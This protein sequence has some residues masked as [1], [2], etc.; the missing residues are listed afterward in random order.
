MEINVD[1]IRSDMLEIIGRVPPAGKPNFRTFV[2]SHWLFLLSLL[3]LLTPSPIVHYATLAPGFHETHS[4][5]YFDDL[6]S[7]FQ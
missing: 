1:I 4:L 7:S 2:L 3:L 6:I 5:A